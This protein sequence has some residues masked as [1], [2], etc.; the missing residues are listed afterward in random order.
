[1]SKGFV[2]IATGNEKYFVLA[3]NLLRTYRYWAKDPVPFCLLC[4]RENEYTSEF[5]DVIIMEDVTCSILDKVRMYQYLPYDENIFM[6]ADALAFGDMNK[7]W[8]IFCDGSDFAAFGVQRPLD[9][10]VGWFDPDGIGEF[11]K[12]IDWIPD[13]NG[14]CYYIRKSE[15]SQKCFSLAEYVL[16]HF[17]EFQFRRF[18][19]PVDENVFSIPLA[20]Y[21]CYCQPNMPSSDFA[22]VCIGPATRYVQADISKPYL[23]YKSKKMSYDAE[24]LHFGNIRTKYSLYKFQEELFNHIQDNKAKG[25][26]FT[27]LY[28]YKL[29]FFILRL[30]D[31]RFIPARIKRKITHR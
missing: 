26:C 24:V 1:M 18:Q 30:A 16:K 8:D 19:F 11:G 15:V 22:H 7:W 4:D 21:H 2:T 14:G 25:L 13:F 27:L 5:D 10:S 12:E 20:V 3:R 28:K 29:R 6:D 23:H 17:D 9:S 31:I